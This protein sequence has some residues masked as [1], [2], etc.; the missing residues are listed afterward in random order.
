MVNSPWHTPSFSPVLFPLVLAWE[1]RAG[2]RHY[3]HYGLMDTWPF[4]WFLIISFLAVFYGLEM[5]GWCSQQASLMWDSFPRCLGFLKRSDPIFR[6]TPRGSLSWTPGRSRLFAPCCVVPSEPYSHL[7]NSRRPIS[8][9]CL[10]KWNLFSVPLGMEN[11]KGWSLFP[12][13]LVIS[14]HYLFQGSF[15]SPNQKMRCQPVPPEDT[16][17]LYNDFLQVLLFPLVLKLTPHPHE[18]RKKDERAVLHNILLLKRPFLSLT[19]LYWEMGD[20]MGV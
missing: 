12:P 7:I 13:C 1:E 15:S 10:H 18:Q 11:L 16:P 14:P 8:W 19:V 4:S 6:M 17:K 3:L 20:G 5:D 9:I 2:K